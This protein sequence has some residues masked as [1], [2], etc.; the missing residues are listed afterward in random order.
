[1][2]IFNATCANN[3]VSVDGQVV[4][5]CPVMGEGGTSSGYLVIS[6]SDLFYLPKT[7]PDVKTLI[8]T[9]ESLIDKILAMT[10]T[11]SLPGSPT[12]TPINSADF[13]LIK[14]DLTNLK[15]ALR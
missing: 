11:S 10:M 2:R 7:T 8:T 1:M 5:S 13:T 12:S 4:P 9:L 14:T 6:E 3:V 15:G